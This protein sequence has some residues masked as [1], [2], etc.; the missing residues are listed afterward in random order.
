MCGVAGFCFSKQSKVTHTRRAVLLAAL[1]QGMETRGAQSWGIFAPH[2]RRL[3]RAVG[4]VTDGLDVTSWHVEPG[5]MLHTRFA[6]TGG[7]TPGNAHPFMLPS[8]LVGQHNGVVYNHAAL[9]RAHGDEP[10]DSIHLLRAIDERR[11]LSTVDA[12]GS[13]QYVL[14]GE[15]SIR[16]GRFNGGELA[17]WRIGGGVIFAST[18]EACQ[19]AATLAGLAGKARPVRVDE[20]RLLVLRDG[21]VY[22]TGEKLDVGGDDYMRSMVRSSS[23]ARKHRSSRPHP[24]TCSE[25]G[26]G[27]GNHARWCVGDESRCSDCGTDSDQHHPGCTFGDMSGDRCVECWMEGIGHDHD[28]KT[29]S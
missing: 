29:L 21:E 10:V 4:P 15:T 1:A 24:D 26:G 19:R 13:V 2:S 18:A 23:L 22:A 3:T 11:P 9:C 17:V 5:L 16:L 7:V 8:G 20:G 14:P 27:H 12:Y 6:T 28:C 25:C